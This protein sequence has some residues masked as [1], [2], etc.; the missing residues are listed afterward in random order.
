MWSQCCLTTGRF[1]VL[2]CLG[3]LSGVI[4]WI[5]V[6]FTGIHQCQQ[7]LSNGGSKGGPPTL[8]HTSAIVPPSLTCQC[9]RLIPGPSGIG[10]DPH[11]EARNP[12]SQR[13]ALAVSRSDRHRGHCGGT[14]CQ[15]ARRRDELRR[16]DS[17]IE[18]A[19]ARFPHCKRPC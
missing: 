10:S 3:L 6:L 18:R 9:S 15:C 11:A 1:P 8:R 4:G 13:A 2:F 14:N 19:S 16:A 5:I 17:S 12:N 7:R